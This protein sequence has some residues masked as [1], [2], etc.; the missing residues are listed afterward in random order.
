[1]KSI[2]FTLL[3][4]AGLAVSIDA[5]SHPGAQDR[6]SSQKAPDT[7]RAY[8]PPKGDPERNAIMDALRQVLQS[9]KKDLVFVVDYLKVK[10][11]WAWVQPSPQSPDGKTHLEPVWSLLR[12]QGGQWKVVYVRPCCGDCAEDPDCVDDKRLYKKL[13]REF[14]DAPGEIFP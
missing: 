1:M 14:P 4:A 5:W 12:K 3:L 13:K 11:G 2:Y 9:S 10:D 6:R 8:T 7:H